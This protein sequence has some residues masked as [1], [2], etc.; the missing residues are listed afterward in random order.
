MRAVEAQCYVTFPTTYFALRAESRLKESG[1]AF[2]LVPVPRSISS[3]CGAALQCDCRDLAGIAAMLA[4]GRVEVEGVY[5]VDGK[6]VSPLVL[7]QWEG[8]WPGGT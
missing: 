4:E 5:R 6:L 1:Y 7:P 8:A 3:S 2:R